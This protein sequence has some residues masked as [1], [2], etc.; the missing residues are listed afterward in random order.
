[1]DSK[2]HFYSGFTLVGSAFAE[3]YSTV[4]MPITNQDQFIISCREVVPFQ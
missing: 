2:S 1:M 4:S 3:S